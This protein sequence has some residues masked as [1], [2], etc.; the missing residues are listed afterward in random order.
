L[1]CTTNQLTILDL[2]GNYYL[3]ELSCSDNPLTCIK[4]NVRDIEKYAENFKDIPKG[5]IFSRNCE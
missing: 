4:V 3:N 1:V 2:L 5:A